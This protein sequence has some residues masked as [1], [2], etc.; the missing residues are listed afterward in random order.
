MTAL[1]DE[2]I[3][4]SAPA[5]L[6]LATVHE[7]RLK[8]L[9]ALDRSGAVS[10]DLADVTELDAVGGAVLVGCLRRARQAGRTLSLT[11]MSESAARGLQRTGLARC[12]ATH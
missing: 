1:V 12:L 3:N 7:F 6:D 11:A 8:V 4:L 2:P 5:H 10:V 9:A